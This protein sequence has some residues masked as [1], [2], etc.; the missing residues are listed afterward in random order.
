MGHFHQ[1][2]W[3][4]EN[5]LTLGQLLYNQSLEKAHTTEGVLNPRHFEKQQIQITISGFLYFLLE[6]GLFLHSI[7]GEYILLR[8]GWHTSADLTGSTVRPGM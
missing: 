7:R 4:T 2:T 5:L 8:T 1:G 6:N 3:Y